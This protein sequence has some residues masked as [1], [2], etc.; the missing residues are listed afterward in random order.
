MTGVE[1]ICEAA[2][3]AHAYEFVKKSRI[4]RATGRR[5]ELTLPVAERPDLRSLWPEFA[6]IVLG[7]VLCLLGWLRMCL[8]VCG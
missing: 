6:R 7:G 3:T 1:A 5:S 8:G 4:E 2:A